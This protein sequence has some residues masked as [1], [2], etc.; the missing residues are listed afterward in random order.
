[1]TRL[2]TQDI[3][4]VAQR[5]G[6]FDWQL[7]EQRSTES[8]AGSG[9]TNDERARS[10]HIDDI[11]VAQFPCEDARAKRAVSASIDA[12]KKGDEGHDQIIGSLEHG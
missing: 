3:A 6:R 7:P 11:E 5:D 2:Q 10:P 9:L 8:G 4:T 1:M 12:P